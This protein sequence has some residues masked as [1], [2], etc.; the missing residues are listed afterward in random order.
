MDYL[1]MYTIIYRMVCIVMRSSRGLY[2][3]YPSSQSRMK[4]WH[5]IGADEQCRMKFRSPMD[6]C[7]V[8]YAFFGGLAFLNCSYLIFSSSVSEYTRACWVVLTVIAEL[9]NAP[10]TLLL[11]PFWSAFFLI[12]FTGLDSPLARSC[13]F[14]SSSRASF[15]S[16][17]TRSSSYRVYQSRVIMASRVDYCG[18]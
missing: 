15:S 14:F 6:V 2:H 4:L 8:T 18:Y 9:V 5:V 17:A 12:F 13:C 10:A 16:A 1:V 3:A 7:S 11:L